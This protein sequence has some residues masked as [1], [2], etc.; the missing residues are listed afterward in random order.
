MTFHFENQVIDLLLCP[1]IQDS[2][3]A[4]RMEHLLHQH[5]NSYY[6]DQ[7]EDVIQILYRCIQELE[8]IGQLKMYK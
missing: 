4:W 2:F 7:I 1:S 5:F 3:K 6:I 8:K